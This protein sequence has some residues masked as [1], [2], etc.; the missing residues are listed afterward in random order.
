[1]VP[2]QATTS[3]ELTV[4]AQAGRVTVAVFQTVV[5]TDKP[6]VAV[7][8]ALVL[9]EELAILVLVALVVLGCPRLLLVL[10][11]SVVAVALREQI[12]ASGLQ[13]ALFLG[14]QAEVEI[15]VLILHLLVCRE[16]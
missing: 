8:A 5:M 2:V 4:L 10:R 14:V 6:Q 9:L 12:T 7:V 1:M 11:W 3:A 15:A 16:Q 13:T